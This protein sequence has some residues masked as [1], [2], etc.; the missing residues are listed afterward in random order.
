MPWA[1]PASG[2][3]LAPS[4]GLWLVGASPWS[5]ASSS[6]HP[7]VL[8]VCSFIPL[9]IKAV[10]TPSVTSPEVHLQ[11]LSFQ[12]G[13]HAMVPGV[14]T[15]DLQKHSWEGGTQFTPKQASRRVPQW[16]WGSL[17]LPAASAAGQPLA[18]EACA[19][20]PGLL[21]SGPGRGRGAEGQNW[22]HTFCFGLLL[23]SFRFQR[24]LRAPV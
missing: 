1:L 4:G 22:P 13:S 21:L 5:L 8:R 3:L 11:P 20:S 24:V 10:H 23:L 9:L 17:S 18:L 14:G 7:H 6:L 16:R 2:G 19:S 15:S 12:T